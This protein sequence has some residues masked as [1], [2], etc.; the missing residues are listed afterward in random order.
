MHEALVSVCTRL[1]SDLH[2]MFVI[3]EMRVESNVSLRRGVS[4][5]A[6]GRKCRVLGDSACFDTAEIEGRKH[7]ETNV[8][9]A[10]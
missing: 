1:M 9:K 7:R 4:C 5:E 2:R 10:Q 8:S 6:E 3:M